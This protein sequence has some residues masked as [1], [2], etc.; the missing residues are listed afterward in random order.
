MSESKTYEFQAE[1]KQLLDIVIHSLYSNRDIFL[2]ELVSNASDALDKRRFYAL[3]DDNF[4]TEELS[5]KLLPNLEKGTLTIIDNG[6]GMNEKELIENIGTIARSGTKAFVE[7]LKDAANRPELIGQFGVGFYSSFIVADRVSLLTRRAGEDGPALLW[8]SDGSGS[9]SLTHTEKAEPGTEITLHLKKFDEDDD[10][11][12]NYCEEYTLRN[13]VKTYSDFVTYPIRM[14]VTREEDAPGQEDKKPEDKKEKV[15][16]TKTETLNSM[17]AL[18][19]RPKADVT[20]EEYN[21]FY[22][23]LT[24]DF[25]EP[26]EVISF[27]AEG[28]FEYRS[29]LFIPSQ[30]PMDLMY[31]DGKR[32]LNLYV[33][34]VFIM[35]NCEKLLP[36]YLRFV[37][38]LV[39]SSDLSLNVSREL[40]QEDRQFTAM[41]KRLTKKILETLKE[42][43]SA[44]P[45]EYLKFWEQFGEVLKEGPALDMASSE[46]IKELLLFRSTRSEGKLI[47]LEDY[48]ARMPES[49][50]EIYYITGDSDS[51]VENSPLLEA[52][53]A[54]NLEVIYMT[55][56]VDEFM[57][58]GLYEFK[59]KKLRSVNKGDVDLKNEEEKKESEKKEEETKEQYADLLKSI[60][61]ELDEKIKEVRISQ[62]L[63]SSAVCL[64][65]DEHEMTPQMEQMFRA[66]GQEVPK[67][68]RILEINPDHALAAQ[69]KTIH[70]AGP[71]PRF[72][73][74]CKLLLAQALLSEGLPVDNP[75]AL[76]KDLAQLMVDAIKG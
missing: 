25:A 27:K 76:A 40:L 22:R 62:R 33:K 16:V 39:D 4:K 63:T 44:K 55:E 41:K 15:S 72:T 28:T 23:Q 50:K 21:E 68:K 32:G 10:S 13:L 35:A 7:G 59:E 5:I 42:L 20:N 73:N 65:S 53:R 71:S 37:K 60:Q 1:V 57:L 43:K 12:K 47:S 14:D 19:E 29:L 8:Q 56:R 38:G 2:R 74:Y 36:D 67:T 70:A 30:R 75:A 66:M 51:V 64:V 18:W 52:F 54:K 26:M 45:E 46:S 34:K 69:L 58:Q 3:T 48:V 6:I 31:R 24:H 11:S 9:Y 17:K 61:K 49:Q